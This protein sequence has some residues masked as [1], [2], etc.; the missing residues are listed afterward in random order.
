MYRLLCLQ[1]GVFVL[2]NTASSLYFILLCNYNGLAGNEANWDFSS[3]NNRS[4]TWA[5]ANGKAEY[6]PAALSLYDTNLSTETT[7]WTAVAFVIP[8]NSTAAYIDPMALKISCCES[9]WCVRKWKHVKHGRKYIRKKK[10]C[11]IALIFYI[12]Q[13]RVW[14]NNTEVFYGWSIMNA[15][16][17]DNNVLHEEIENGF[18]KIWRWLIQ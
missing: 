5:K 6:V 12:Y 4:N 9:L 2:V 16:T 17:H 11:C 14:I 7:G 18:S 1:T 8:M 15:W 13:L 3:R 10:E